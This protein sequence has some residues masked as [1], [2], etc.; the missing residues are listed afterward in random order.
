MLMIST[1]S[2][3]LGIASCE[4]IWEKDTFTVGW[5]KAVYSTK[6]AR[7]FSTWPVVGIEPQTF[8]SRV[9]RS[10]DSTT[11]T[12]FGVPSEGRLMNSI[13][14]I[15]SDLSSLCVACQYDPPPS[16]ENLI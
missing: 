13:I 11:A 9:R 16:K 1:T 14:L 10:V 7:Y 8:R 3:I 5:P 6:F 4:D 12:N 2:L 15:I